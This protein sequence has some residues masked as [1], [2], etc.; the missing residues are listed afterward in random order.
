MIA[1]GAH[2][3]RIAGRR[4]ESSTRRVA[5]ALAALGLSILFG[6]GIHATHESV[7]AENQIQQVQADDWPW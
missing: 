5:V 3:A 6:A 4:R 2:E 1:G 7:H